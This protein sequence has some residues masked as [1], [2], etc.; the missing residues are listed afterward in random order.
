MTKAKWGEKQAKADIQPPSPLQ[1]L[2]I[3]MLSMLVGRSNLHPARN[4]AFTR[5]AAT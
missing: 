4:A 2:L 1:S 5:R 3:L